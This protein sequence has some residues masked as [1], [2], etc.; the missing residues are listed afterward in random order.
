M[1]ILWALDQQ[2]NKTDKSL[3][4]GLV[5]FKTHKTN[6]KSSYNQGEGKG[7]S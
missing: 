6:C 4:E 7:E 3:T 2:L 1:D 5:S